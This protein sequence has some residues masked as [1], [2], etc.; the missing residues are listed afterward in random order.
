MGVTPQQF[1]AMQQ[2]LDG[3]R[4]APAP[5]FE[6]ALAPGAHTDR[7]ILGLDPS[8]RG[9]G[10]GVIELARPSPRALSHGTI[11]CPAAWERSRC[12]V[13][14]IRTLREVVKKHQPTLC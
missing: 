9:T 14:I 3:R 13:K 7:V 2:R 1:K 10:Y 8:L 5:V 12:L 11:S 4:H 6:T